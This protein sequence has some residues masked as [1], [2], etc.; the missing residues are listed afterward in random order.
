M[1]AGTIRSS[2]PNPERYRTIPPKRRFS[3]YAPPEK[4][5][6]RINDKIRVRE[7]F[8]IGPDGTQVGAVPTTEA[9]R[10]AQEADLDL[11]EV[12]PNSNPPVCR[13]LDYGKFKYEQKKKQHKARAA[14]TVLKEVRVRP[15]IDTHDLQIKINRAR[16]FLE[17]GHKVQVT[18]LFRG[19][20]MMYQEIGRNVMLKV[21]AALEELARTER[22]PRLEGR[23]MTLLLSKR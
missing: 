15:K 7:V 20:E 18:C 9:R 21:V 6:Y 12:A 10:V 8:L 22:E 5:R 16:S 19:R 14:S 4:E 1:A 11:V 23:R 13:V 17:E 2:D 3:R